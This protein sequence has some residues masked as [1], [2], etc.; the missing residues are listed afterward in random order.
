[1][2]R[3]ERAYSLVRTA[4]ERGEYPEGSTLPTQPT[5]ARSIGVSTVTLRQALERLASEG[6][7]EARQG[8]GTYVRSRHPVAGPVLVADDDPSVRE[9]L[10]DAI[11]E[12][13]F[14]VEGVANG[15]EAV[16]RCGDRHFSHVFLDLRMGS[17]NGAA[18]GDRI[19][20]I[21]PSTVVVY[22]TAYPEDILSTNRSTLWPALVLRKPFELGELE[23]VLRLRLR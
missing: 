5:L 19:A 12:L 18:A 11:G 16:A 20:Q 15:E 14:Q 3:A 23:R 13:G 7:I 8:Q 10:I 2:S 4:I 1:M 17:L 6:F 21:D 22:V 9:M